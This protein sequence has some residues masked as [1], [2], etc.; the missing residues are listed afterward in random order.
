[1]RILGSPFISRYGGRIVNIHPSLL[2]LYPGL[3]THRQAL[4]DGALLHGATV[5]LVTDRLDHGPIL[6][7]AIAPVLAGDSETALAERVLSMEHRLYPARPA[8]AAG[9]SGDDRRRQGPARRQRRHRKAGSAPSAPG[10][11]CNRTRIRLMGPRQA[12]VEVL[13][14]LLPGLP[15]VS[16]GAAGP[17]GPAGPASQQA[18][19]QSPASPA[20]RADP[21]PVDQQLRDFF[22]RHPALG[23]RDRLQV[24]DW[25]FDVLRNLR[26]YQ[27][28]LQV[29]GRAKPEPRLCARELIALSQE[30][31]AESRAEGTTSLSDAGPGGQS[32]RAA[33]AAL[34]AGFP[35]AVRYSLP[36]WL[37]KRLQASHGTRAGAIASSLLQPSP[38]DLRANLLVGK[39]EV[40]RTRLAERGIQAVPIAGVPTGLRVSGRPNLEAARPF[41]AGLVRSTGRGQ[42]V[43]R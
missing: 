28:L 27:E 37:W 31:A 7:Q 39:A 6:A 32:E 4:A 34:S 19:P 21:Q 35:E 9:G 3:H 18:S 1:M 12:A 13:A 2:P 43:D 26:L 25:I 8:V 5:H 33:L 42:P 15:Q 20:G 29:S 10:R 11:E 14:A 16:A 38:I 23:K 22:R 36:D 17:A 30:A 24:S 40:L 41:R